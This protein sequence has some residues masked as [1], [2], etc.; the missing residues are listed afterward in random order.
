MNFS[1]NWKPDYYFFKS[2][3]IRSLYI[4]SAEKGLVLLGIRKKLSQYH[5]TRVFSAGGASIVYTQLA[6]YITWRRSEL[7]RLIML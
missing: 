4:S 3:V 6:V 1:S 2:V 7:G 5:D